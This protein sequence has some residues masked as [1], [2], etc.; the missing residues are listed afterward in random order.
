VFFRF[1]YIAGALCL[2]LVMMACVSVSA[3]SND[4]EISQ[5]V[6]SLPS[7]TIDAE[8]A[9]YQSIISRPNDEI[10]QQKIELLQKTNPVD[11]ISKINPSVNFNHSLLG[12]IT[13]PEMRGFDGRQTRVM[14]DGSPINTPWNGSSQLSGFPLRRL[15]KVSVV[16]GGAALVYGTSAMGGAVNFTLPTARNL[17]GLRLTQEVGSRGTRHQEFLYGKIAHQNEH[18]FGLFLDDYTG[19][20][21][22]KTWGTAGNEFDNAMWMYK[23]RVDTDSGWTFKTTLLESHGEISIPNY[24]QRFEPWEMSHRD[25]VVEKGFANNQRLILRYSHYRDYSRSQPYTDYG[26]ETKAGKADPADDVTVNMKNYEVLYNLPA[27]QKHFIT[28]GAQRQSV[29]DDG[30]AVKGGVAN[31]WLDSTGYFINDSVT[32]NDKLDLQVTARVDE[33]FSNDSEFS[34]SVDADYKLS[35]K[36]GFGAGI[37]RTLRFPNVQELYRGTRVYG[38]ENLD[39][40]NAKNLEFRL[41]HFLN[42]NWE[43]SLTRYISN[44]ENMIAIGT[45]GAAMN[46]PGVGPVLAKDSYYLNID[47]AEIQGWEFALNGSLNEKFDAWLS[48]TRFDRA[49]DKEKNLRLVSQP[50]YRMSVGT[51]F[52][53]KGFSAILSCAHQ[54]KTPET[55]TVDSAGKST[56]YEGLDAVTT[57][58]LGL[59]HQFNDNFAVY[60]NVENLTDKKDAILVQGSDLKNKAGLLKDPLYYQDRR[61]TVVGMEVKF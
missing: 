61:K 25:F 9:T 52:E 51:V 1:N 34:W 38:N 5:V 29:K 47:K 30:H 39:P 41:R 44:V 22:Y 31:K 24:L 17:P 14:L 32:A 12:A 26:L 46:I 15:H 55:R 27:S 56:V 11:L 60:L 36:T 57:L 10:D 33:S 49:Q 54:G 23:G 50:S 21:H 13:T 42:D 43:T 6:F 40:E 18:L 7:L 59:R 48:Y 4:E 35:D 37:S 3:Q 45:A 20:K 2:F 19:K 16:P 53:C 58:D 28:F 8:R